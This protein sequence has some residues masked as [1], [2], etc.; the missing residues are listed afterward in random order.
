MKEQ[1]KYYRGI[2]ELN[3]TPEFVA[4][5]NSE[6]PEYLPVLQSEDN[7]H[8]RRDFLKLMG[9]S[10]AAV[11]LAACEAPIKKI[12]P[13]V[14]KPEG[15]EPGLALYYATSYVKG[16]NYAS[17]LVR[18]REGRP[19]LI[20][21]NPSSS[22]TKGAVDSKGI[23]SI[24]SLYDSSRAQGFSEKGKE[25]SI[26][27]ADAKIVS[28]LKS[29]SSNG[30]QIRLVSESVISPSSK[31]VIK[32]FLAAYPT[33]KHVV[34]DAV[35]S[36]ALV[37]ANGG[38]VPN[39]EFSKV[40]SVVSF[41]A[42]FLGSYLN[43]S[44]YIKD[45]AQTRKVKRGANAKSD[46][47]KHFQFETILSLTGANS[48]VRVPIKPSEEGAFVVALYNEVVG[49]SLPTSAKSAA[50]SIAAKSLLENKGSA[51]VLSGSND[52]SIQSLV[53]EIN[54]VLGANG[55]TINTSNKGLFKQGVDENLF[56]LVD[57]LNSGSVKGL[58]F[59]DSNPVYNTKFGAQI[60]KAL[61]KVTLSVSTSD[62]LDE[63]AKLCQFNCPTTH[64][65]ESWGDAEPV[66]GYYSIIQP[67]IGKIFKNTRGSEESLL[68]WAGKGQDY[69]DF[70]QN[71]WKT[72]LVPAGSDFFS[73]WNSTL[74]KGV[75]EPRTAAHT[76]SIVVNESVASHSISDTTQVAPIAH[77]IGNVVAAMSAGEA[78]SKIQSAPK[79]SGLELIIY[80]KPN[81][82]AGEFANIPWLYENPDPITKVCWDNYVSI[83]PETAKSLDIKQ[84]SIDSGIGSDL[85]SVVIPRIGKVLLPV[86]EQP[87]QAKGTVA[88]AIGFGRTD[89]GKLA[90][91]ASQMHPNPAGEPVIGVDLF[92]FLGIVAGNLSY[93]Y[94]GVSI[95][96]TSAKY[97]LA[98]TQTHHTIM[99]RNIIQES[100][101]KS[102]KN[103]TVFLQEMKDKYEILI[104]TSNG[105]MKPDQVDI[106]KAPKKD[107]N[108]DIIKEEIVTHAYANHHWGLTI[109]LNSCFGCGQCITSCHAENNVPVVGKE[110]V[111]LKRDMHWLRIDRYYKA[112]NE[113]Q[114]REDDSF[115]N[116]KKLEIADT[117]NPEVSFQPMMCQHCN[118][119]PCETV[120]PMVATTHSSEGLN[121]MTYNRCI[122]TRYCANNC[123]Y[124]VRRFNWFN[125]SDTKANT[126]N[127]DARQFQFVNVT[128]NDD[129]GKMV[130]NPDV[131]VR[132]RGVMEK[133]SMCAQRIQAGKLKAKLESRKVVDGDIKVACATSCPTDAI[134]FGDMNDP[135]SK[136]SQMLEVENADRMYHVLAEV[137][138]KPNVAYL[139]K[140]RNK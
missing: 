130:I 16:A 61:E 109:D 115:G 72:N 52:L 76:A 67:T 74:E 59:L 48:D 11:S 129:L 94:T 110:E 70:V 24:L 121:Q 114:T 140:I 68:S 56:T 62:R 81:Q 103:E 42:D 35:S 137:N 96:K 36:S 86:L 126:L 120:C 87:G 43:S 54:Q 50:I 9:F 37:Q 65:L 6:F 2:E 32:E 95:E 102:Y 60:K 135:N 21:G 69:Y 15:I 138:A 4:N 128:T 79:T 111:L 99:G 13:Y 105:P 98:Q 134:T 40:K 31:A 124:K 84:G 78:A 26:K 92:P 101:L 139:T 100:T 44:M 23:A 29:I 90:K 73:F 28:E 83:N 38:Y 46:M 49:A 22:I 89:A 136:I 91:G 117:D 1:E 3:Q 51:L 63:T 113:D 34:Y 123:P 106:W 20:E 119:A 55:T 18:T 39:Y 47:S 53:A 108:G 27:A 57:E 104:S 85:V 64:F 93:T 7:N 80:E 8:T 17:I 88:V 127:G 133:C 10:V 5:A 41:N 116:L 66:Q 118:H 125:Y 58:I 71:Y 131:T 97:K 14:N 25:L 132:A 12:I 82:G 19:I 122:G 112:T 77:H 45:F 33:A 30:G 75:Y 107:E